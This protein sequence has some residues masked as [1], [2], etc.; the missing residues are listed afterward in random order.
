MVN[1]WTLIFGTLSW[2]VV[3]SLLYN[4]MHKW[5]RSL[6]GFSYQQRPIK[7]SIGLQHSIMMVG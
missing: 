3:E 2:V 4:P 5:A 6:V 7:S 1:F